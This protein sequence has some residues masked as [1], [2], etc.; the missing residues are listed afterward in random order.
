MA[1]EKPGSIPAFKSVRF[2]EP[3]VGAPSTGQRSNKRKQPDPPPDGDVAE[4]DSSLKN[5]VKDVEVVVIEQ[6]DNPHKR[7]LRPRKPKAT[8]A[9]PTS[10]IE[11]AKK[12][13]KV[14]PSRKRKA[15]ETPKTEPATATGVKR[16]KIILS[17]TK[18]A[19]AQA[20]APTPTKDD[21]STTNKGR[22]IKDE[23]S[24]DVHIVKSQRSV[25]TIDS[26]DESSP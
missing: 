14:A 20:A 23:S 16:I 9:N 13:Q 3:L 26:T 21:K 17:G 10:S 24:D 12:K 2:T 8:E 4:L 7:Q 5:P 25:I 6:D 15:T 1:C 19:N 18:N 11:P 22:A